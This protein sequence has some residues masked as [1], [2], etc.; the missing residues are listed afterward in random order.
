MFSVGDAGS[1]DGEHPSEKLRG[2][3][4]RHICVS[5]LTSLE[6][7]C[8]PTPREKGILSCPEGSGTSAWLPSLWEAWTRTC[9]P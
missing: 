8:F 6:D 9:V 5:W 1:E 2:Y 4:Y 7:D 3:L